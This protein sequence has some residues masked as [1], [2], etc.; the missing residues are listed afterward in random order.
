VAIRPTDPPHRLAR[1]LQEFAD[2]RP[3]DAAFMTV[4][5]RLASA[6]PDDT[7]CAWGIYLTDA[8]PGQ[9]L[10]LDET[11]M[12]AGLILIWP[13]EDG[14]A[15]PIYEMVVWMRGAYRNTGVGRPAVRA[16]LDQLED[17]WP[18]GFRLRMRLAVSG[19]TGPGGKLQ[20]AMWLTFFNHLEFFRTGREDDRFVELQ[21]D[22]PRR[23]G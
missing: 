13:L 17:R 2:Q 14:G 3:Q 4:Q 10:P 21:R 15:F 18:N 1:L 22:F 8:D 23:L 6:M 19:M 11:E 7:P 16:V 9:E 20:K 12:A 5:Q